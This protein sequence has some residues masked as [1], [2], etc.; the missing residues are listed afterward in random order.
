MRASSAIANGLWTGINVAGYRRFRAALHD[1]E[2]IQKATLFRYLRH[3]AETAFGR[4]HCFD[5]M[6][7]LRAY[8][9]QVPITGYD[10]YTPYIDRIAEGQ[11]G[12]LTCAPVKLFALSSGSTRA[13]KWI[14][15][16]GALQSEFRRGVAPWIVDLMASRPKLLGGPAYWSISPA[17][18]PGCAR[19][20]VIPVG[21]DEDSASLGGLFKRLVDL[22]LPVPG[23]ISH[24]Q[25]I[26]L[27]RRLTLLYLLR[28][29]ELRLISIWHPSF[30]EFL[31]TPLTTQWESLLTDIARGT[32]FPGSALRSP[33]DPARARALAKLDPQRPDS[34]WPSLA[35]I[36]CWG[37]AHA[38]DDLQG[39]RRLFPNVEV[40][41]KG[42]IATEAFASLPFKGHYPL[43][44]TSHFFEFL[45]PDG[46]ARPAWDVRQGAVYSLIVTTGGGLY[47][48]RL[49]DLVEVTGFLGK[50]PCLRFLGKEDRVSDLC[51]EKLS[52]GFVTAALRAVLGTSGVKAEFCMLAP[53]RKNGVSRYLLFLESPKAP[54]RTLGADLDSRLRENPHYDYCLRIGQL[55]PIEVL[56]VRGNAFERYARRLRS[57]GQRLGDIKPSALSALPDWRQAFAAETVVEDISAY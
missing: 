1:P 33:A 8:Q 2:R 47:R 41:A 21:F 52:E 22:A 36:S 48:Y 5:G 20:S 11:A 37:S 17:L 44:V 45:G 23:G 10:A 19:H 9:E 18:N 42:L 30:L 49:G 27:F 57:R 7:S 38:A 56:R 13:A 51:G 55:A 46:V 35:L 29:P 15:Y 3:N 28:V 54:P 53:D 24:I 39:I 14:P 26:E 32:R 6:R 43:A 4:D 40:Q 12:V 25:D 50:T 31:L 34:I 16:T